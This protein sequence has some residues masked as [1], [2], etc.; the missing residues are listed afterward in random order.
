MTKE[1]RQL[2]SEQR[3]RA[4]AQTGSFKQC[5]TA[6]SVNW[7]FTLAINVN[8][9]WLLEGVSFKWLHTEKQPCPVLELLLFL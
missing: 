9:S 8:N 7:V 2:H 1:F 6:L 5:H 4:A 3:R